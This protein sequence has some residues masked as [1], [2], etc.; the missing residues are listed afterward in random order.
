MADRN[1]L[2]AVE[3]LG[4]G[5]HDLHHDHRWGDFSVWVGHE[6]RVHATGHFHAG[7]IEGGLRK[8]VVHFEEVESDHVAD[9]GI[10]GGWGID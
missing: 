4:F 6:A 7:F 3:P 9:G 10:D 2:S 1:L 8:G 5:V